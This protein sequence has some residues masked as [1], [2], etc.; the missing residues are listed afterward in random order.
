MTDFKKTIMKG[1][2]EKTRRDLI[3][4]L[5][6]RTG[7]H[8]SSAMVAVQGLESFIV[9][10][11]SSGESVRLNGLMTIEPYVAA[12]RLGRD[13]KTG[14]PV[15]CPKHTT[16]RVKVSKILKQKINQHQSQ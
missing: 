9:Q 6:T 4:W 3:D 10:A 14:N 7:L 16:V 8:R 12:P 1:K 2:R 15:I 11:L 13:F 5:V